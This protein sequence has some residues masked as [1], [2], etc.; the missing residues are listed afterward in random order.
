MDIGSIIRSRRLELGLTLEEVGSYVG[1]G[2]STVKKWES[3]YIK[4]IKRDKIAL[5][6]EVLKLSPLTFITG[7]IDN[8]ISGAYGFPAPRITEDIVT[9]PVI[10]DVAAGYEHIAAEDWSGDTIDI[11]VKYLHGRPLTDYIVLNVH[12]QSMYPMY[13][14]GDHV[15]VL[16]TQTLDYSGQVGLV[17]YDG[18]MATLKKVEFAEGEDWIR[19]VP[20]NPEYAPRT[21]SGSDLEQCSIIGIP[22]LIIRSVN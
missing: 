14:D 1:V 7:E 10:G 11:P 5:L 20:I 6:A 18:E 8:D 12:G 4:N 13:L 17:R 2:K 3:G 21:I 22:K 15:L 16:L 9:M 19:L